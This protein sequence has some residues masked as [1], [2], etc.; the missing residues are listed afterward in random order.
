MSRVS[1]LIGIASI[2]IVAS[3]LLISANIASAQD[4]PAN[5]RATYAGGWTCNLGYKKEYS[6]CVPMTAA[7]AQQQLLILQKTRQSAKSTVHHID[8]YEFSLRDIERGCE[9]YVWD[10]EYGELECTG[11]LRLIERKCEVYI[12]DWPYGE[13]DCR[14]TDFRFIERSCSVAMYSQEYGEVD[15]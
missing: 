3:S 15:C 4:M 2:L 5:A 9:A 6:T 1:R 13:I 10:Q 12:Y 14:G 11:S 8:G 7:E